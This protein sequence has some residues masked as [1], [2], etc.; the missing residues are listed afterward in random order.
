MSKKD[1]NGHDPIPPNAMCCFNC[2]H[3]LLS[4]LP[5]PNIQKIRVCKFMP[6]VPIAKRDFKS[7]IIGITASSPPVD[8][9]DFCAQYQPN[10]NVANSLRQV[11]N[12][13]AVVDPTKPG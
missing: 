12:D 4:Q 2:G 9:K 8:D 5:P 7:Q 10:E 11:A 3:S 1:L 6:P 13:S